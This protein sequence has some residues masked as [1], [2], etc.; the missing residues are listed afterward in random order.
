MQVG[1]PKAGDIIMLSIA[2]IAPN[3][4]QPRKLF[5]D[6]PLLELSESIK[7]H[8]LLQPVLV[9]RI[10]QPHDGKAYNLVAGERRLRASQ[11]AGL[12]D[13][14]CI[15]RH[16]SPQQMLEEALVENTQRAD[17]NPVERA[18]AY[19][20]LM[21]RFNLTQEQLA[22]R[23]GEPRATIANYLR[24]LDLCDSVQQCLIDGRLSFGHG[25]VLAALAGQVAT[26]IALAEKSVKDNL[27]V[28]HL[29]TLVQ[30]AQSG[31]PAVT[32]QKPAPAARSAYLSDVERQ[33]TERVGTKVAIKPGRGKH[34]G[35]ILIEYYSLEDFDRITRTLG[36]RIES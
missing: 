26:Q 21:D 8:G 18:G 35:K 5:Q 12:L 25:K 30:A 24:I 32:V 33:L 11:L 27:S 17:L 19:R 29:E 15:L 13:I 3:P 10:H 20:D 4:Y 9:A 6:G 16:G 1:P 28:R 14:P 31:T 34:T 23:V 36:A 22:Q 2:S 7:V